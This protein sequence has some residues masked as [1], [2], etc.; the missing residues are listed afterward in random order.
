MTYR[1]IER[2][3]GRVPAD[4]DP[5]TLFDGD[6]HALALAIH[7]WGITPRAYFW[8]ERVAGDAMEAQPA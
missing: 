3:P 7:D 4:G 8:I 1:L 2:F 5:S 6:A